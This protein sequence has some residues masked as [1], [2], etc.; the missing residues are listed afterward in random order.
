MVFGEVRR[1]DFG[2]S[3]GEGQTNGVHA[4]GVDVDNARNGEA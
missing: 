3:Q 4:Q 1:T 2:S